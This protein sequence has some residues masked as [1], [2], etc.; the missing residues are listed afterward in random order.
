MLIEAGRRTLGL[1]LLGAVLLALT[2][3]S[4]AQADSASITFTDAV[5]N[6]DPAVGVGR[7][8]SVTGNS[9]V[10]KRVY[11]KVRAAGG[12][13]C[14]PS[15]SSDAASRSYYGS[16][17]GDD[18]YGTTVNGNF[19]LRKTGTWDT[20]GSFLFCTWLASTSTDPV[21]P[22][23]QV[24]TFRAPTGSISATVAPIAPLAGQT[25]TVTIAGSSEAPKRVYSK[26]R[27]AGGAPCAPSASTDS[28]NGLIYGTDVNG[29]FSVATTTTLDTA[30]AY[31]LCMWLADSSTDAAPV[32]GPQPATFTV[33]EPPRPCIVPALPRFTLLAPY[34]TA[35]GAANCT[36]GTQRYTPSVTFP[37]GTII[38]T[39][40][41]PGTSLAPGAPV[42]LL[43]SR[44]KRCRVPAA[45]RGTTLSRARTRLRAAGCVPGRVRNVRS[46]RRRGTVV[47]F[48][49]RSGTTLSPR[50]VV[51]I[52]LSRGRGR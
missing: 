20:P 49:P 38:K 48:T 25:A 34:L 17:A 32:A 14:A 16:F 45:T 27:P 6:S 13:P 39:T 7:T 8:L 4:S 28:G 21:A 50:A 18:L 2:V 41:V 5:G 47:R 12:A 15:A 42:A 51:G 1:A 24:V 33:T 26:I 19:T 44:G 36:A 29:A 9:A 3:A 35:L 52:R 11:V 46:N 23:S 31:L 40:P 30:G 43:I 10:S 37:R 22:F